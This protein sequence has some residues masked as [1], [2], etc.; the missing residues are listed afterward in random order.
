LR[1]L[2]FVYPAANG[3]FSEYSALKQQAITNKQKEQR[4]NV[5]TKD[6]DGP[7]NLFS[8]LNSK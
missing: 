3:T 1:K 2:S 4:P 7:L 6:L 5:V 8:N